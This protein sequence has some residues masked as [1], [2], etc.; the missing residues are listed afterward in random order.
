MTILSDGYV[1]IGTTSPGE[2]LEI[3][4]N[5]KL[6]ATGVIKVGN[7]TNLSSSFNMALGFLVNDALISGM[8]FKNSN[9][10]GQVRLMARN[11]QDDY[12][13]VTLHI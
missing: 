11:N 4:G 5:L 10:A 7:W 13:Y 8:D 9:S 6:P 2:M 12:S 1:G 3:A